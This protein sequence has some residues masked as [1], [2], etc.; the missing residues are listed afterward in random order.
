MLLILDSALKTQINRKKFEI[1][2]L[3]EAQFL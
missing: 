1:C 3:K 2:I